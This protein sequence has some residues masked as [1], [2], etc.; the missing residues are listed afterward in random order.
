M[1]SNRQICLSGGA[2]ALAAV[3]IWARD[4][5]WVESVADT[6][7][8]ALGLPL[9]YF[10]G[11]PWQR[12]EGA[13]T[14]RRPGLIALGGA[15][16][17]CGWIIESLTLLAMSW[18]LLAWLWGRQNFVRV[19]G[20]ERLIWL[21]LLSFPWLVIEWQALGWSLRLSSAWVAEQIFALLQL[22][23]QRDGT[24]LSILGVPIEI[25]AA[26][27]G[28]NLLQLTLLTGVAYGAYEIRSSR[29]F[30]M[31]LALLPVLAWLANLLRILIL[32]GIALSFDAEVASGVLHGLTG[33]I[34]LAAVLG[35]TKTL[36]HFLAAPPTPI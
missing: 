35:M 1:N 31:L 15:G 10:L 4:W 14:E 9:A 20:R 8:L 18:S 19:A 23:T 24:H 12:L 6:L 27:A 28:W 13:T 11:C 5:R 32:A 29:R 17:A 3:A 30:A 7:P 2:L 16:F 22:P 25:E 33:L 36:C 21:L 26:C 34:I